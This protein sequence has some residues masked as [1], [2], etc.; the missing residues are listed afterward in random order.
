LWPRHASVQCMS[1]VVGDSVVMN[2]VGASATF[3]HCLAQ[4]AAE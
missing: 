3:M 1:G 4:E 2:E